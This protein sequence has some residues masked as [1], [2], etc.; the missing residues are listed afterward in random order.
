MTERRKE[1]RNQSEIEVRVWGI[2]ADGSFFRK[3]VVARNLS[4]G[5]AL[6]SEIGVSLRS[7]DMVCVKYETTQAKFRVVWVRDDRAAIQKQREEP[8]PW[9]KL[10]P[11]KFGASA[12]S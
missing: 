7:G 11:Q 12:G 6:L 10:L 2:D 5:G 9:E 3:E 8:C 4:S 1:S